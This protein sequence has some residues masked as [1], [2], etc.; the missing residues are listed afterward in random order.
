MVQV[1]KD[2]GM[3]QNAKMIPNLDANLAFQIDYTA[4]YNK[5]F[6]REFQS[7]F[8]DGCGTPD[9]FTILYALHLNPDI[10]QSE[11]A[12]ILFK[13]KA[14]VGKILNDMEERGLIK[15]I[16]DTRDNIIIKR[17]EITPKGE[18]VFVKGNIQFS[19]V[20]NKIL[21]EYTQDE[22]LQFIKYLTKY[23]EILST[24]VDVKL[25]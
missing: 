22:L 16:A 14:H 2:T 17:N 1:E 15:R 9:E 25:K 19:K 12:K 21:E 5:S 23:R 8:I 3:E 7:Q 11:L 24:F 20:R 18:E 6:R 4:N 10:S 13:G